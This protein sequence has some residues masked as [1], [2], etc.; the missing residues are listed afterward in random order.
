V[1]VG[2]GL[3]EPTVNH[4]FRPERT[5]NRGEFAQVLSRLVRMLGVSQ[6]D[7]API[8]APDLVPGSPLYRELQLVVGYGLLSLDN[9]G[10]FSV[11][12]PVSGEEAVNT[13]EKL[14][15]LLQKKA[16]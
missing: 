12:A 2:V 13:A 8:T 15:R 5:V 11:S 9:S 14:L 3:L 16:A 6:Q 1:V 4:T 7:A 10:N